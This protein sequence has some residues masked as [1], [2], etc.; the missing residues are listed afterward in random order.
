MNMRAH[1]IRTVL[2]FSA[3]SSLGAGN[4]AMADVYLVVSANSPLNKLE[5]RQVRSIYKGRL[6][7]IDGQRVVP[8]N[9]APGSEDRVEFL[10]TVMDV[11][12]LDYTGYWHVRR[13]SGQG[14]PPSEVKD[15]ADMFAQIQANPQHI[16]Y[17]KV[18]PGSKT[19]IPPGLKLLPQ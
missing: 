14:T 17:V 18:G 19:E 12:E 10:H 15:Q 16:G 9:A 5:L 13:Y 7:Q 2:V 6:T 4:A 11:S 3:L 8:L 1:L